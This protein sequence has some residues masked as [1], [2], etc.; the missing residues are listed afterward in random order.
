MISI[1]STVND[2]PHCGG[3]QTQT[4]KVTRN[5]EQILLVI[6]HLCT[7]CGKAPSTK[8]FAPAEAKDD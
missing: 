7:Q 2:C 4:T 3:K 1:I 5:E 8:H 6:P